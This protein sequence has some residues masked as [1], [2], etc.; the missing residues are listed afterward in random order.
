M[1][2]IKQTLATVVAGMALHGCAHAGVSE[3]AAPV[4]EG[5]DKE[6]IEA[7]LTAYET[8][9][10]SADVEAVIALYAD[11]GVFMPQF[12]PSQAG[13]E[14]VR[15]TYAHV[16]N[17]IV[18]AVTFDIEE[19]H[20]VSPNWAFARTNSAGTVTVK[21]TGESGPEANQELFIFQR[22]DGGDW[23]IARYAFSSTNP[24]R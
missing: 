23:K 1:S 9:L 17:A 21:A 2:K 11:D 6:A 8:A 4:N 22:T 24:P 19:V 5:R 7:V 3:P 12:S 15:A 10:N 14:A 13:R 16:F 18:L 20:V